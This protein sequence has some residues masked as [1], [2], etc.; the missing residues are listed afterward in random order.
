MI[1]A[2]PSFDP[3]TSHLD[4][5]PTETQEDYIARSNPRAALSNP[6]VFL[7]GN[8]LDQAEWGRMMTT[9]AGRALAEKI[10]AVGF[11]EICAK[12]RDDVSGV[13][14]DL[15][16]DLRAQEVAILIG[17]GDKGGYVQQ[18]SKKGKLS[19]LRTLVSRLRKH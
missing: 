5:V 15:V 18:K 4:G 3:A 14:A 13:L 2:N 8:K 10:G 19:G 12:T 6:C 16:R 7:V 1:P 11:R 9:E 17:E